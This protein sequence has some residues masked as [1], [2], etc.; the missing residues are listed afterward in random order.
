MAVI[1]TAIRILSGSELL[2]VWR[3]IEGY[4]LGA[5]AVHESQN[6]EG[7]TA[8]DL[9]S[10]RAIPCQLVDGMTREEAEAI[11]AH[12]DERIGAAP[13]AASTYAYGDWPYAFEALL[14]EALE[15]TEAP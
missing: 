7:W 15:T 8:T 9:K 3:T 6:G 10:G 1:K 13:D 14:A 2:P 5:W 4:Q 11:A 12:L